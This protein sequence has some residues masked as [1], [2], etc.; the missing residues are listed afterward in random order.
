MKK[1]ISLDVSNEL[2]CMYNSFTHHF[3][4]VKKIRMAEFMRQDLINNRVIS[5]SENIDKMTEEEIEEHV[6]R[7]KMTGAFPVPPF[8]L[9]Q[10]NLNYFTPP[11]FQDLPET[12]TFSG[13]IYNPEVF[14]F[15]GEHN[16]SE[17]QP[18]PEEHTTSEDTRCETVSES[19]TGTDSLRDTDRSS[20][21]AEE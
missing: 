7:A 13:E 18:V 21:P 15:S 1:S 17:T 16:N 12:P 4:I 3:G 2:N 5:P 8:V 11:P 20:V 9:T 6:L 14:H 19:T 10:N